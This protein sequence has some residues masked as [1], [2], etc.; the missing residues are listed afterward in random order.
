MLAET[1]GVTMTDEQKLAKDVVKGELEL[2]CPE[3]QLLSCPNY[4]TSLF[5]GTGLIRTRSGGRLL[6]EIVGRYDRGFPPLAKSSSPIHGQIPDPDD[7]VM[8]RAVDAHGREWRSNWVIPKTFPSGSRSSTWTVSCALESLMH[9]EARSS[10]DIS[11]GRLYIELPGPLPFDQATHTTKKVGEELRDQEWSIDHHA[12]MINSAQVE[13]RQHESRLLT[14]LARQVPP[15]MPDWAG[16]VCQALSLATAQTVR[17]IVAVREFN[18]RKDIGIFS[19]PFSYP[20]SYL[21]RPIPP[22]EVKDFWALIQKF[23]E[24]ATSVGSSVAADLFDELEGI[25]NGSMGSIRT[26]ALTL[27]TAVESLADLLLACIEVE[28]EF[29]DKIDSLLEHVRDWNGDV[30]I[31]HRATSMLGSLKQIRSVDRLHQF[32]QIRGISAELVEAWKK[33]RDVVAHGRAPDSHQQLYD[34]YFST[35]ELLYR[36]IAFAIGYQGSICATAT[37][38]WGLNE[39]GFPA[40]STPKVD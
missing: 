12:C 33:L 40:K 22:S 27:A 15:V 21:T 6:F 37:H 34:R 1:S 19:G 10:S 23:I 18:T 8:L 25:R 30:A 26:A 20:R 28:R 14:V 4:D 32:V 11:E 31:R 35:T 5:D 36:I 2:L 9:V 16:L 38:G 24:W 13:F 7:H 29:S 39:W 17:P 3:M